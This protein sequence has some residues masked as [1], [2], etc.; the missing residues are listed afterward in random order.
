MVASIPGLER[1][2]VFTHIWL[3]LFGAWPWDHVPVLPPEMMLLPSW[4]PLNPYDFAC[5]ARQTVVALTVVLTYRPV[6]T[7]P[8]DLDEL[9]GPEPWS[10]PAAR[11]LTDR[12]L[13]GLDRVLQRCLAKDPDQRWQS[14]ADLKAALEW[15]PFSTATEST[16]R[17]SRSLAIW[18][19][20]LGLLLIGSTAGCCA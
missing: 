19:W 2:R 20:V 1:A 11:S 17:R 14:A 16:P 15:L 18:G 8:F 12:V 9:R 6:R 4:V 10:P 13:L 3:A 5:W 7:L